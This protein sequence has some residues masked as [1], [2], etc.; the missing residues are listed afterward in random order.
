[1]PRASSE[2]AVA[3]RGFAR[4]RLSRPFEKRLYRPFEKRILII[5]IW[6]VGRRGATL[7][8]ALLRVCARASARPSLRTPRECVHLP[9]HP[10]QASELG[11]RRG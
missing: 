4:H 2:T 1:M 3:L 10:C 5:K 7:E 9:E 11:P 8:P 6:P